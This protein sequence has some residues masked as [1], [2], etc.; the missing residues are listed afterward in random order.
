MT[1]VR[2]AIVETAPHGGLLH[3]AVQLADAL[4]LRGHAVDVVAARGNELQD[5]SGPARMRA[6]L[7][8]PVAS[9][10]EPP[11]G[12]AYVGRRGAI[13]L[14]L[15]RAW[16]RV[17]REARASRYDAVLVGDF[18]LSLSAAAGLLLTFLP[19]R[20]P[21]A[22][23]CHNVRPYNKWG[24]DALHESSPL[25]LALLR[26]LYPRFELVLVHGE[27]SR[28][29]FEAAWP[30][31]RAAVI[32]HGD[33]RIFGAPP[34]PAAEERV[35]FFG[36]WRKVKGLPVLM[37]AFDELAARRP[38]ARLT[39]AGTPS[40]DGDPEV[41]RRWAAS[42]GR[43]VTVID[44]Y[45]PVEDVA[46][47]F[48]SARVVAVPYLVASQ[49]GVVHLAMTMGRAV[50]ASDVG[51][52]RSAVA[53]GQSGR[54]VAPADPAALAAALEEILAD[55]P[56]AD[57]LGAQARR[58]LLRHCSWETVAERVEDELM[59]HH[60]IGGRSHDGDRPDHAAPV[61]AD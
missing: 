59:R 26:R 40:P 44:H 49:S 27:R 60:S 39:I 53:D 58:R 4:A 37:A 41:V 21:L 61:A 19:G 38:A 46:G 32:P 14:R 54:L 50:V 48:G 56:L 15:T 28:R 7:A 57:R 36:D 5:H 42:H 43:R 29:E 55:P 47:L 12:L 24:G 13:A 20:P 6:V 17:L 22:E 8:P 9:A 52:L 2:L 3:Y 11:R 51:D 25:L 18:A 45:V 33:E 1:P 30:P 34:P 31:A 16:A 35:L 10:A 23:I